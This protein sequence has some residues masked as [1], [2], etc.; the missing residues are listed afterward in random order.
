MKKLILLVTLFSAFFLPLYA[1]QYQISDVIYDIEG[2][3][4]PIF[5][6]TQ[7]YA[8]T[9]EA[10]V[11]TKRVFEDKD[12]L[13]LYLK[14]YEKRLNNLRAFESITIEYVSQEQEEKTEEITEETICNVILKVWVKDSFHLFAIPGPKYDSNTGL[15]FKLKIKDSNFLGTLN[16]LSSDFYILIPTKESDGT[17]TEFGFNCSADYPFKAGIFDAVWLND[18]GISY[19][20]GDSMPEFNIRTGIR[21]ILPFERTSLIIETNQ[22]FVNNFSFKQ[23]DDNLYFVNDLKLSVP[24]IITKMNYFGNLYYTPYSSASVN[25]DF[26]G[27]S[28]QNSS[29]SSPVMTVGHALSFGRTDWSQNLRTGFSLSLDNYYTYNF[30]RKRLYPLLEL[31]TQ[32]F[33]KFDLIEDSYFLRDFGIC[34]DLHCFTFL[35]NPK[36]DQYI[37]DDGKAI[38]S[39]LRGIRDSQIYEVNGQETN[40]SS[41][42][43]TSAFILNLD[44]PFHLFTT[45]FTKGFMRY[46]NFEMQLSPFID[47]ALCYNK[48]TQTFFDPK[49]GFYAGGLE[50]IVYPLKWSGITIRGSVGIDVGRKFLSNYINMDWRESVSKK[51]FSI[52][53]G[54]HY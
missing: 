37:N 19:T 10:P 44:L 51:E 52:G 8:L 6:R 25:W 26:D 43:P 20:I 36:T 17:S 1:Q 38:G 48:I 5:G 33:K 39:Y 27:I 34:A 4:A 30:Q 18:F 29:L 47:L 9:K 49:D 14:D 7:Y 24:L 40:I 35:F 15:T 42:H 2:C 3:G 32:V 22:R 41:L 16:T 11:D 13:E 50:V 21:F 28:K 12:E 23:Y 46:C 45:N 53:F 31:N 54:L